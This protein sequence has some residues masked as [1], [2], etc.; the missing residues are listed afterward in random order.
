[1]H[2]EY[3]EALASGSQYMS[4]YL[5]LRVRRSHIVADT[6]NHFVAISE[7]DYKKPL[8]VVFDSEEGVDA[9]GVR[10]EFYQVIFPS[11]RRSSSHIMADYDEGIARS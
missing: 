3:E 10:K 5:V 4:P 6:V 11:L 8:K 9:G 7:N 1:M 2:Q